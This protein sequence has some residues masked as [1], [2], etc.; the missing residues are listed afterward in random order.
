M[1]ARIATFALP[2]QFN[3]IRYES[4]DGAPPS[5]HEVEIEVAA[6]ALNFKDVL[7][8]LAI[9]PT[10][11]GAAPAFGF[12]CA[13]RVR[14]VGTAVTTLVPGDEV[15]AIGSGCLAT[16]VRVAADQVCRRPRRLSAVQ[17]ATL[18]I[19]FVTAGYALQRLAQVGAD[20]RVLIHAASGG[21]GL[22]AVQICRRAGAE[23]FATAGSEEKRE[24]LR[25]LGIARVMNS[26]TPAFAAEVM[27]A[28]GGRGVDVVLNSLSGELLERS[29][30][31]LA[32]HGRFVELGARD[33]IE[34]RKLALALFSRGA[35]FCAVGYE[36]ALPDLGARLA[37]AMA[38]AARGDYAPLPARIY[39]QAQT[40][41]A[42]AHL[43]A[44]RHIGKVVI[45][46]EPPRDG[47]SGNP[48]LLSPAE[49]ARIFERALGSGLSSLAVSKRDLAARLGESTVAQAR[50]VPVG[51]GR[52]HPRPALAVPLAAPRD[53]VERLIAR[54]WAEQFQLDTVGVNDDFFDLG[55]D[56][57]LAVQLAHALRSALGR[58]LATRELLEHPTVAGL[59]ARLRGSATE[60]QLP[61]QLVRLAA[62]PLDARPLFLVH[63]IGG[64][65]YFYLPMAAQL[66]TAMPVYGIQAQG[67]D[68]E[69]VPLQSIENM[70]RLYLEAVRAVQPRGPYRLGGSSFGGVVCFEMARQL[71]TAG[72]VVELLALIDS[73]APGSLP[74]FFRSDAEI[75]AYLLARGENPEPH[76]SALE[77]MD[78]ESMLQYFIVHG[79]GG[80]NLAPNATADSVRHLLRLFRTNYRALVDYRP[81]PL[82]AAALFFQASEHAVFDT[83]GFEQAWEPFMNSVER[84]A[85]PGNHTSM[86][87][88]PNCDCIVAAIKASLAQT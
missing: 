41:E 66:G 64:H 40:G 27:E 26:R 28:T 31:A 68:G 57:L 53:D 54:T 37:D 88:P 3:S 51:E 34:G 55:G 49:G 61:R 71:N 33:A 48:E 2:G 67:A 75:L 72:E 42:F 73:P 47:G 15:V 85:V 19:A 12:E 18:P 7:L 21:V 32:P 6:A 60:P 78:E 44:A 4:A 83:R 16:V 13:G 1:Q 9:I 74:S 11:Q 63:P 86:N 25:G 58:E 22:A 36:A 5:A 50:A 14:R 29:L 76:R 24:Y 62:G 10:A 39:T 17:A 8:A 70:A 87:V 79:G 35:S 46:L 59:A 45:E 23:I 56:S 30:E 80:V 81:K 43:A 77:G 65:V 20:D 69:A 82:A 52:R 38:A 84:V